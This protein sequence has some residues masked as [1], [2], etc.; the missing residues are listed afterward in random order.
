[1]K[2]TRRVSKTMKGF[3]LI[4]LMFSVFIL[5]LI[6]IAVF[7]FQKDIFSF[8]RVISSGLAAQDEARRA[9]RVMT[10][11]IRSA[12]PSSNGSY[13]VS[14][15]EPTSFTFYKNIDSDNLQEQIRYFLS[16][17]TLKKGV[18]KPSGDP[19]VYNPDDE[20]V[21][22]VA[23]DIA[24]GAT[25]IFEYYD[26]T[27]DGSSAP[28]SDPFSIAAVRLVKITLILDKDTLRPPAP[29]TLT[30]QVSMRNLKDNL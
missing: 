22:D 2:F 10:T 21:S 17:T 28:L 29:F 13:P 14:E 16:G 30:T 23:H 1:M 9:L 19:Y 15:A 18:I 24:N 4:E 3:S 27:Y 8:N 25:P 11:E 26:E 6:G 7:A 5:S 12:S 20:E